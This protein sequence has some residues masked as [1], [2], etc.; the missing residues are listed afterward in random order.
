[1]R[2]VLHGTGV[3][4]LAAHHHPANPEW[5]AAQVAGL[6]SR[7]KKRLFNRWEKT[8]SDGFGSEANRQAAG[9]LLGT[10][11]KLSEVNIPLDASDA[12]ICARAEQ[13]ADHC[14]ELGGVFR[15]WALRS[16]MEAVCR[17]NHVD[18]PYRKRHTTGETECNRMTCPQWWRRQLRKVHA[19]AVEGAAISIGYVNKT[20]DI[21]VSNES[22]HRRQQQNRRNAA[23][24]E[25]TKARNENGQEFTL[26]ELA[27][28]GVANKAIRRGELMTRISGFEHIAV[29][30]AHVGLF[31]TMT[32]PSRMHKWKTVAGGKVV[33]NPKYDGTNPK[34]AQAYLSKVWSRVRAKFGRCGFGWYGFRIAEPN[35]DGT[36][37]WHFLVFFE[38]A[39]QK[40]E[41]RTALPRVAAIVRRYALA[42]SGREQGAKKHRVDFKPMDAAKG[43]A[44]GY[45]AKY[46]SKN[47]DGY[48]IEKDLF[49][50][51][52]FAASRRV[53]AWAA[54][55]GIHQ[56]QQVGGPPVT[57]W[58]EMRRV[59]EMPE[60]V[61]AHLLDAFSACNKVASVEGETASV[62]WDRYTRAQGGV[63]CGRDYRIRLAL[64]EVEGTGR[65][66]EALARRPVGVETVARV[67]Y[68]DGIVT[69]EKMISYLV[70]SVRYAWEI[71]IRRSS[72]KHAGIAR[73][74][75]R[76]NNCTREN[77]AGIANRVAAV[78]QLM[79]PMPFSEKFGASRCIFEFVGPL[80]LPELEKGMS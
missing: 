7:W 30:C 52:A 24:M 58:R 61:P 78:P 5:A 21:Y 71:I 79:G 76:V 53:E 56:F 47:I 48:G 12:D 63:F 20:R 8:R 55:W 4:M 14:R 17:A 35:H 72:Q 43:T 18:A 74:W 34:E 36:P 26:A 64:E 28:K 6:P 1:M 80:N 46:V 10:L 38:G 66:G 65:Y 23:M 22:L 9:Q 44:A 13:L 62:A 41:G 49:G 15:E 68:R 31:F 16:A 45:I 73:A 3:L 19:K 59:K 39:W 50:N 25:A 60:G 37:H 29:E 27:A 32:C 54:T 40:T 2:G 33:E 51:D 69:G 42:D 70:R 57:V 75:T 11:D 67:A 77:F